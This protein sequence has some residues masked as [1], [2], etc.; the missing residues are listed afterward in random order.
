MGLAM[1]GASAATAMTLMACYG[2]PYDDIDCGDFDSDGYCA[3]ADCDDWNFEIRPGAVDPLGD[4]IDQN[5]DGVD[6]DAL[7]DAGM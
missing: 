5:C 1:I 4:G 2:S 7:P 3:P 6:G